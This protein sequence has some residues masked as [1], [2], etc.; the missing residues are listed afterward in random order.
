MLPQIPGDG[1]E[2]SAE[3]SELG[4]PDLCRVGWKW[5]YWACGEAF[6]INYFRNLSFGDG[7]YPLMLV[8]WDGFLRWF[9]VLPHYWAKKRQYTFGGPPNK[10]HKKKR[11]GAFCRLRAGRESSKAFSWKMW[12]IILDHLQNLPSPNHNLWNLSSLVKCRTCSVQLQV[13]LSCR[14]TVF[15]VLKRIPGSGKKLCRSFLRV[16]QPVA[17]CIPGWPA[18]AILGKPLISGFDAR[19]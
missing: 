10:Q 5:R 3:L 19:F 7:L 1:P 6:I 4:R 14:G 2:L 12:E 17:L 11:G 15:Q 9:M 13:A 18:V 16:V 8:F